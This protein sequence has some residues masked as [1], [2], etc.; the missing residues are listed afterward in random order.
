MAGCAGEG[1]TPA[2]SEV[3]EVGSVGLNLELAPGVTV[4][5]ATYKI[6]GNGFEK[7]G[8]LDI[9]NT[10]VVRGRIG[11]IP[12]GEDFRISLQAT[13]SDGRTSAGSATFDVAANAVTNVSI[14]LRWSGVRRNGSIVV[15][16]AFN[17]CPVID[18]LTVSPLTV[19]VPGPVQLAARATDEGLP[20]PLTY[21]WTVNNGGAVAD[22]SSQN[23]TLTSAEAGNRNVTL[24]VSDGD[25]T[26][27][28]SV[29]V[30]FVAP[31]PVAG[32]G[33]A[34]V[35][36][37]GGAGGS[38]GASGSGQAHNNILLIIQ[39]DYGAEASPLYPELN[40]DSGAVATP[41]IEALAE[42]GLVFDNAWSN[43]ACSMTRAT[44]LSGLYGHRT[45][46]TFVGG[47]LP[48]D[49]TT[50]FDRLNAE[51]PYGSALFGKYHVGTTIQHP[52]DIGITTFKGF[53]GGAISDYYN[54]TALDVDG[55]A[56]QWS[57]YSTTAITDFAVDY[58][59]E[60]EAEH[61]DAPWFLYQSY[62]GSHSPFQVPPAS[63]HSVDVGGQAPGTIDNSIANYKAIIQAT[64]TEIGRL[65]AEVDLDE[66]TVI[67]I[68]D[69]G[70]PGAQKDTGTGVRSSKGSAFEGGVRVPFVI[71]GAGVTRR[72][73]EDAL[74]NTADLYTTIL[75]LAGITIPQIHNSY[76][77]KPL[78]TDENATS[79]R[80]LNFTEYC[81]GE[82]TQHYAIRDAQFKLVSTGRVYTLYDLAND[83][84]EAIDLF[85]NPAYAAQQ[86]SLLAEIATL[87]A[88]ATAGCLQ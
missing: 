70:T 7:Q 75:E 73:R 12:A 71:A 59:N 27:T 4:D 32:A 54:W 67:Y 37:A 10:Q 62:N 24:S 45:G 20:G 69:N 33:S 63:L 44:I 52:T 55:P 49:T 29:Q 41:N 61:P 5:E 68:G 64:D 56:V 35:G 18:E 51:T 11:G 28:A 31:P 2:A 57:T 16:G 34:G 1:R 85:N 6:V 76:S 53:L 40:G 80:R 74:V 60:Y 14:N 81:N 83:P 36:G 15:N 46:V 77:I 23:A 50:L 25:C 17:A 3:S 39:D 19:T 9:S 43:P 22:A 21:R 78:L 13:A 72:G 82:S 42:N 79:G 84:L 65:L 58:I 8:A 30:T 26:E 66:T 87:K 86:A 88:S 47:V 48:I 38:A